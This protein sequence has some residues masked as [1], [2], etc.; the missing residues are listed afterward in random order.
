MDL[1]TWNMFW[2]LCFGFLATL[3]VAGNILNI[4]MFFKL[5]RR[6]RS[7]FLLI[8]LGVADLLV[9][10]LAIPLFIAAFES[11]SLT[12]WRVFNLVDVFASTSSIY[13]LAVISVERMFAI[14]WLLRHTTTNFRVYIYAISIPWIIAAIFTVLTDANFNFITSDSVIYLLVLFPATPLLVMCVA[15]YV[16]WRKQKSPIC[17]HNNVIREAKLANTLFFITGASVFTW[18]PFQILILLVNLQITANFSHLQMT[19]F[20]IRVLQ[21]SNSF[22]NVIIYPLRIPEFKNCL[23]H[24]L[25]CCVVPHRVFRAGVLPSVQSGSVVSL[26]RFTSTQF[27]SPSSKLGSVV[28]LL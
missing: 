23:L 20:I 16:I 1:N 6:K 19:I 14:G 13:A 11:A 21:Y 3:I 15:Y 12:A 24:S 26:V 17:N 10:G 28:W 7:S 25:R 2:R 18:L 8:G 22:V 9:G 4:W 27:L 5:R